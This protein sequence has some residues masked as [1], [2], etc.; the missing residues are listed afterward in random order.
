MAL[1]KFTS[2]QSSLTLP[3]NP[4]ANKASPYPM[5]F[6]VTGVVGDVK[7]VALQITNFTHNWPNDVDMVLVGPDGTNGLVKTFQNV[8]PDFPITGK[9][10][11]YDQDAEILASDATILFDI[12]FSHFRLRNNNCDVNINTFDADPNLPAGPY[13]ADFTVFENYLNALVNGT[14]RLYAVDNYPSGDN[15]TTGEAILYIWDDAPDTLPYRLVGSGW[16]DTWYNTT[17]YLISS[18]R[19]GLMYQSDI[20]DLGGGQYYRNFILSG[21]ST[22]LSPGD[23]NFKL[24]L[25]DLATGNPG[26]AKAMDFWLDSSDP[27]NDVNTLANIIEMF[28]RNDESQNTYFYS[29]ALSSGGYVPFEGWS[30]YYGLGAGFLYPNEIP[31]D[32]TPTPTQTPTLTETPTQ[33]PTQTPTL[34]ETPTYTPTL[35]ETPT[36]TPTLTLTLTPTLTLT[37]TVTLTYTPQETP[38]PTLPPG[39]TPSPT[40]TQTPTPSITRTQTPTPTETPTQTPTL[41]ETPTQTPTVTVTPSNAPLGDICVINGQY[42][43]L[44]LEGTYNEIAPG[45]YSRNFNQGVGGLWWYVVT[46]DVVISGDLFPG[47]WKLAYTYD[48]DIFGPYAIFM[49]AWTNNAGAGIV[50]N[51]GWIQQEGDIFDTAPNPVPGLCPTPTPTPTPTF[52][53]TATTP[54]PTPSFTTT[55]QNTPTPSYTPWPTPP[56]TMTNATPTPTRT[57]SQFDYFK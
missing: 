25:G 7:K 1:Y 47:L 37:H 12:P 9:Y 45:I 5:T 17:Y 16:T 20:I 56:P 28:F 50:P 46:P 52:T 2:N 23:I 35:T 33:T 55:P 18:P 36:Y 32:P 29:P 3:A 14:W 57:R 54:T 49:A 41:T 30:E 15:G 43:G 4:S 38:N 26:T 48:A 34:T 6:T 40:R 10:I 44:S 24:I 51:T 39:A 42:F 13:G 27:L 22:V 21:A 19:C 53:S 11:L 31:I 8:S